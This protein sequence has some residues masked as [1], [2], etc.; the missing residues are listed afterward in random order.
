M[1]R[2]QQQLTEALTHAA[3]DELAPGLN[4]SQEA[5]RLVA[6]TNGIGTSILV[7]QHTPDTATAL[8]RYHFDQL[9]TPA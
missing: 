8:L 5:A 1:D 4:P 9:F 6:L 2:L 3:D 7:G